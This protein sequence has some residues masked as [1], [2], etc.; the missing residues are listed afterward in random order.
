EPGNPDVLYVGSDGGLARTED[1]GQHW[2]RLNND[3]ATIQL[4]A[5]CVD[6]NDPYFTFGGAQD[7]GPMLRNHELLAWEGITSGDG[8]GC[9]IDAGDGKRIIVTDQ[10]GSMFLSTDRFQSDFEYVFETQ[11]P[12]DGMAGCGDRVSFV[13]PVTGHPREPGTFYI[14]TYRL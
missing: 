5:V 13:P 2:A 14:G 3:V 10:Y 7:N 6:P 11:D 4:Y 1:G 8:T 12:C 9:A